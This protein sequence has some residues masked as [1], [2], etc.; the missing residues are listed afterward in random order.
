MVKFVVYNS[1]LYHIVKKMATYN[2]EK[3]KSYELF[4]KIVAKRY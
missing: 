4:L 3:K 2:M 1:L